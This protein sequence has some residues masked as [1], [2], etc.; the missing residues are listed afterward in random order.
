M[1]VIVYD[2]N[3]SWSE[4]FEFISSVHMVN[5]S[6]F[7]FQ[8][9]WE[10]Y[11]INLNQYL[12]IVFLFYWFL[13]FE[14]THFQIIITFQYNQ[15]R[16]EYRTPVLHIIFFAKNL[17]RSVAQTFLKVTVLWNTQCHNF[18]RMQLENYANFSLISS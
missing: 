13:F 4:A 3:S 2:C 10:F 7:R 16:F 15:M 8:N 12:R 17:C 14:F 6:R 5:T 11:E 1:I 18:R 9:W